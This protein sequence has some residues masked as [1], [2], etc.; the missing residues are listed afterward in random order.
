V[1]NEYYSGYQLKKAEIVGACSTYGGENKYIQVLVGKRGGKRLLVKPRLR[2]KNNIKTAFREVE[3]GGVDWIHV[4]QDRNT[5]R[6][7][8]HVVINLWVP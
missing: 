6:A 7:P 2:W 8:V 1:L 4:A 5:W 3:W